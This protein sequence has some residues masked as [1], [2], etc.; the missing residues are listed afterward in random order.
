MGCPRTLDRA[1]GD[2]LE[3]AP[4]DEVT[5]GLRKE[6]SGEDDGP[7]ELHGNRVKS[8]RH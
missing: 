2:L 7:Q 6:T 3:L 4:L 1:F 5:R 8:S